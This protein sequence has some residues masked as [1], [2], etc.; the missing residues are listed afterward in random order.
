MIEELL[1]RAHNKG[2]IR[3]QLPP[4]RELS[5]EEL[6]KCHNL[7]K[8]FSNIIQEAQIIRRNKERWMELADRHSNDRD[9]LSNE[10]IEEAHACSS[11]VQAF[12]RKI[13]EFS[14]EC[15]DYFNIL[16]N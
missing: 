14:K 10:E 6:K 5:E 7:E 12:E 3:K 13:G 11:L 4:E 1:K 16:L 2:H 15:A 9:S 8:K